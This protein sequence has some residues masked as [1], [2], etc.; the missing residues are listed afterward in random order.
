M[1]L[2]LMSKF[3]FAPISYIIYSPFQII[4]CIVFYKFE[5]KYN[6]NLSHFWRT[7]IN[8]ASCN[9]N[10]ILHNFLIK[11]TV[12]FLKSQKNC[13]RNQERVC[14]ITDF[15]DKVYLSMSSS[16]PNKPRIKK[17]ESTNCWP[18]RFCRTMLLFSKGV[19]QWC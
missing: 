9:K 10:D 19:M 3:K 6:R 1:H 8:E 2:C 17:L 5:Y 15:L 4:I 11:R 18:T 16:I 14:H 7:F 13:N 12:K